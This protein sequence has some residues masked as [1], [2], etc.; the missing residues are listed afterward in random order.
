MGSNNT[1]KNTQTQNTQNRKQTYR[2]ENRLF[3][4]YR[5]IELYN[6]NRRNAH[7]LN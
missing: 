4:P 6:L 3:T 5:V 7:F 1:Q 2:L